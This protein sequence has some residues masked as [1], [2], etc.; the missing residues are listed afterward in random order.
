MTLSCLA[1]WSPVFWCTLSS[2]SFL[3][4]FVLSFV[5]RPIFH[6]MTSM[7]WAISVKIR[8]RSEMKG[9]DIQRN[10]KC[11]EIYTRNE[12]PKGMVLSD[13]LC[14]DGLMACVDVHGVNIG[15]KI[16][17]AAKKC[18]MGTLSQA[19]MRKHPSQWQNNVCWWLQ[20]F[21]KTCK[22]AAF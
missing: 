9:E 21:I 17:T 19:Q 20:P 2:R 6:C 3:P 4:N 18:L 13:V 7:V 22:D 16:K 12:W 10:R 8:G 5:F 14:Y 1:C 11:C 15:E